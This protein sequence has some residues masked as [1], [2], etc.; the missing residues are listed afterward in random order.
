MVARRKLLRIS[1]AANNSLREKIERAAPTERAKEEMMKDIHLI[2][3]AAQADN[4]VVSRDE[5]IRDLFSA[6]APSAG[7]LRNVVWVNP[8]TCD[9]RSIE[10]L[11][12]GAKPERH[13][14]LGFA[15]R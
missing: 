11:E 13:R 6:I 7:E 9:E 5:R 8:T 3:A 2:E 10:W 15:Q 4:S 12:G 1:D 14:K